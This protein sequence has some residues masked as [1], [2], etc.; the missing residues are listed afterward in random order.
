MCEQSLSMLETLR[1]R[2]A[3]GAQVVFGEAFAH[4][5][6]GEDLRDESLLDRIEPVRGSVLLDIGLTDARAEDP[7]RR[8][9]V[10]A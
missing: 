9:L 6:L 4:A 10:S 5:R 8:H 2:G 1:I 7:D 3:L